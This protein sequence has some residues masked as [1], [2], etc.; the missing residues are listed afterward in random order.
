MVDN[1]K[2]ITI[3]LAHLRHLDAKTN[4]KQ[5]TTERVFLI[6][7]YV[8]HNRKVNVN[9]RPLEGRISVGDLDGIA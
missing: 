7:I 5:K 1:L 2:V 9:E 6:H 4:F 8:T 3:K